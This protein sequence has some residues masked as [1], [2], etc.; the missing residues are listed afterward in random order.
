MG[1]TMTEKILARHAGKKEVKAGDIVVCDIDR[2]VLPELGFTLYPL[3]KKVWDA[4]KICL[5]TDH[6]VPASSVD[7]ANEMKAMREFAYRMGIKDLI[8]VGKHGITHV[9]LSERGLALPGTTLANSDSHTCSS[10]ALNCAARGVGQL[11]MIY[12][13]CTGKTWFPVGPT[14]RFIVSGKLPEGVYSRD[15]VHYAAGVYGDFANH[16]VEWFGPTVEEMSIA[17][18]YTISTMCAEISAEFALFECDQKTLDF[19][20]GRTRQPF[21]PASPDPDANYK[22][23]HRIDVTKL[24][25]QVVLPGKVPNNVKMVREVMDVK[26]DQAFVGSCANARLE[27][28]ALVARMMAGRQVAPGV[29]LI[30]TP[31]S[32]TTYLEAVKAG[33]ITTLVEAGAVVTNSTCGACFGGPMG[34]IGDGEVCIS[35]STRNFQGRMGSPKSQVYLGSPAVVAA[36]A[37]KG[38]IADPR[39][40]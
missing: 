2:A 28:L 12:I 25:P 21:E 39:D 11:D 14:V 27:D 26:I 32:Q 33:Y 7:S 1:M 34:M 35:A 31:G 13:M 23:T 15:V 36:S 17:A 10:G 38:H 3:P 19:L 24:E 8:D 37:L 30:V 9:V 29:R 4:S 6:C 40:V 22:A 5:V 16:N 18:R 20:K